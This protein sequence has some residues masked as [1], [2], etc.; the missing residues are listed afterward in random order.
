MTFPHDIPA[1]RCES[2]QKHGVHPDTRP[3]QR[4]AVHQYVTGALQ[5]E[6]GE[7][8]N[9]RLK[10][11]I[12]VMVLIPC[13]E[14]LE[15]RLLGANFSV[16]VLIQSKENCMLEGVHLVLHFTVFHVFL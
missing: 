7:Q 3:L 2:R 10:V 1:D 12:H 16:E 8:V 11:R 14:T 9:K 15:M 13:S 4:T 6:S 5:A